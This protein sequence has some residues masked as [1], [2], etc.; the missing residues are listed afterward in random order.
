MKRLIVCCDGTWQSA[1]QENLTNI[2]KIAMHAA[3]EDDSGV[4]QIVYYDSGVGATFD[5]DD[6][7]LLN[8]IGDWLDKK[9]GGAIGD[10]LEEKIFDAYRFLAFNYS[11]GDEIFI[12]GFSRGAYTARSLCGL[13]YAS[14][15]VKREKIGALAEAYK[16]YRNKSVRPDHEK[17]IRFRNDNGDSVP[18]DFLGCFDTVG[19]NGVPDIISWL[20]I[21]RLINRGHGFH[22]TFLNRDIRFARH[23]CALDERRKAFPVTVMQAS[24]SRASDQQVLERWFPGFHGGVGGG[25]PDEQ[26]FS[27]GALEWIVEGAESAGMKFSD[28]L[29]A[30]LNPDPLA[31]MDKPSGLWGLGEETREVETGYGNMVPH[32][33]ARARYQAL[34]DWRPGLVQ[35][36]KKQLFEATTAR[37]GTGR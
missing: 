35:K 28:S 22:D 10:G 1:R 23:A 7:N 20:P 3:H 2:A 12:F 27:D 26:A 36:M 24:K 9:L 8:E 6:D 14:G 32:N 17:A 33:S 13:I 31:E 5:A 16:L 18:I 34:T 21:D 29:R 4:R 30:D 37:E 15:L 11:P 25:S 19:M